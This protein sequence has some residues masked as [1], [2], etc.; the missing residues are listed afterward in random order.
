VSG[1]DQVGVVRRIWDA[2]ARRDSDAALDL[3]DPAIEAMSHVAVGTPRG[4]ESGTYRGYQGLRRWLLDF[5]ELFDDF[6]A[7]P[8]DFR[9][10]GDRVVVRVKMGGHGK[11]SRAYTELVFWNVYTV[12]EGRV[13]RLESFAEEGEALKAAGL[14]E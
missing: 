2:W 4:G 1:L 6:V 5:S 7:E 8:E 13:V 11:R 14:E 3:Y 12:V 9:D 10:A